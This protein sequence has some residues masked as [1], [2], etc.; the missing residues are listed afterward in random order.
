MSPKLFLIAGET[1]GDLLGASLCEQIKQHYPNAELRG[2]AGAKMRQAGVEALVDS[3]SMA[4]MGFWEVIKHLSKIKRVMR[5]IKLA[6]LE[7]KPDALILIDYPGFNLRIAQFAKRHGIKVYYYVSPQ[8]WAWR[9]GRIHTIKQCVDH[10]AVLFQ[11]EKAIYRDAG[12]PATVAGHPLRQLVPSNLN[13]L[14]CRK[15]LNLAGDEIIIGL[16]PG[17][18]R[19]EVERLLPVMLDAAKQLRQHYTNARF[20]IPAAPGLD[21]SMFAQLPEYI[22][23][24]DNNTYTSIKACDAI[25]CASGTATLEVSLLQVPMVLIYKVAPLSFWIG[26]KLVKTPFIGLCNIVAGKKVCEEL[27]QDDANPAAISK[28]IIRCIDDNAYRQSMLKDMVQSRKLLG[29]GV[30]PSA[31]IDSLNTLLTENTLPG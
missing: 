1:S 9:S 14:E 8:I 5:Q 24:I 16:M 2:M 22:S 31:L 25:V 20:I 23:L 17:S 6:L 27:I 13:K 15:Q 11:F 26:K 30:K 29:D 19:Q 21:K 18:R 12:I 3:E 7:D 10:M 28:A 4:I